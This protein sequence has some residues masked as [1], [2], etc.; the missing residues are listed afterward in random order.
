MH[1]AARL[2]TLVI[3]SSRSRASRERG[4]HPVDLRVEFGDRSLQLLQ[5]LQGQA[6]QERVVG[7]EPAPQGLAELG[8]LGPQPPLGQLGQHLPVALAGDQGSQHRPPR[9]AQHRWRRPS[10]S[11]LPASSRVF[12]VALA[13]RAMG[14]EPAA[15]QSGPGSRSSRMAGGGTKL[16]RSSP[17]SNSPGQPGGVTDIGLA[18]GE[19]PGRAGR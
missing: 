11:L 7:T 5:L 2:P 10:L 16:E 1:S 19:D 9:H 12:R 17:C 13:L 14:L 8:E 4:D 18:T 15:C 3:V 6:D